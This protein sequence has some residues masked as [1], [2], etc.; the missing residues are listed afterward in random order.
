M[1]RLVRVPREVVVPRIPFRE[2]RRRV[3]VQDEGRA[4]WHTVEV[5]YHVGALCRSQ[6]QIEWTIRIGGISRRIGLRSSGQYSLGC[7]ATAGR[8]PPSVPTWY[9]TGPGM[10]TFASPGGGCFGIQ[11]QVIEPA[12][13]S[14]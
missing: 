7:T 8:K 12:P 1:A 13:A 6:Q 11:V 3:V 14:R 5:D 2:R 4:G 9:I 10:S